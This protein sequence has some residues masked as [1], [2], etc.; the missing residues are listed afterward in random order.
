MRRPIILRKESHLG[1]AVWLDEQEQ[2]IWAQ[3]THEYRPMGAAVVALSSQFRR[4][5][6][7]QSLKPLP[8]LDRL[9]VGFFGSLEDVNHFVRD[10]KKRRFRH[11][12]A[13]L[14]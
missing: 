3:G 11:T 9:F 5:D 13:H 1:F 6:F 2:V 14:L 12:P 7:R 8:A 4:A 10:H